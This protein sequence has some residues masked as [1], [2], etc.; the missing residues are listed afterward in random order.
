MNGELPKFK[1]IVE[2]GICERF[3]MEFREVD[4]V[5]RHLVIMTETKI[6]SFNYTTVISREIKTEGRPKYGYFSST[7]IQRQFSEHGMNY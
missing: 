2:T 4:E 3:R 7:Q 1:I 6:F 5:M